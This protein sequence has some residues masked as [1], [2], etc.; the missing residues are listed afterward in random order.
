MLHTKRITAELARIYAHTTCCDV[1]GR[2]LANSVS[3]RATSLPDTVGV[4][5]R[6]AAANK[7]PNCGPFSTP[8]DP[9]N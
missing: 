7:R 5:G 4:D 1:W 9:A 2:G 8:G 6:T 3:R